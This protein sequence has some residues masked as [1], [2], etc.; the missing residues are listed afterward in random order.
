MM[1]SGRTVRK[2]AT[3][4]EVAI[5]AAPFVAE[6]ARRRVVINERLS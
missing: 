5:P 4:Q 2:G 1:A 6:L 3:P